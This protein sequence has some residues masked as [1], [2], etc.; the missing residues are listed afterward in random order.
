MYVYYTVMIINHSFLFFFSF[1]NYI[2]YIFMVFFRQY[3]QF[4]PVFMVNYGYLVSSFSGSVSIIN[5]CKS[6]HPVDSSD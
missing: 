2:I 6:S 1:E 4:S 3:E 5:P